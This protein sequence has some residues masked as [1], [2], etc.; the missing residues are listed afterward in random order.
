[1]EALRALSEP[2]HACQGCGSCCHGV[3]VRLLGEEEHGRVRTLAAALHVM[4]PVENGRLRQVEGRCVFLDPH[5]RCMLHSRFGA[6]AKPLLCQ[7]YP[8]VLLDTES[9]PRI[10][11]DPGCFTGYLHWRDAELAPANARLVPNV[12]VLEPE[13]AANERAFLTW[14][15]RQE[16][17]VHGA[18]RF[19]AAAPP[20]PSPLDVL[21]RRF[22][23]RINLLP[24]DR[25]L[26][27]PETGAPVRDTLLPVLAGLRELDPDGPLPDLTLGPEEDAFALEVTRRTLFLRLLPTLP[28]AQAVGLLSLLGAQCI[29]LSGRRGRAFGRAMVA[30]NRAIRAPAFWSTILPSAEVLQAL[31]SGADAPEA[32]APRTSTCG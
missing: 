21:T 3:S 9:E 30:W 12:S 2:R 10:G 8:F 26:L 15:Q 22:L 20:D 32:G 24:L 31:M 7:Q 29:G 18:I 4:D 11:V 23:R 14:T 19:L 27:R 6:A 5:Q 13:Q 28:V 16:R 1:M 17:T 25:V